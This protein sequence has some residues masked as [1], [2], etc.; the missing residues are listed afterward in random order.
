MKAYVIC[1]DSTSL[2]GLKRADID[3]PTPGSGQVLLKMHA[4]SL[5]FRDIALVT[6][7]YPG[8]SVQH[9]TIALSDGA[10]EVVAL[11]D[12][13][14]ELAVGDRV[15][16][17]FFQG[18]I[19]GPFNPAKHGV[20]G[21]PLDGVLTEYITVNQDGV[22]KIPSHLSYEEAATL[23]CAALTAW[24]A[25]MESTHMQPGQS[26]LALGTGGVSIFALQFARANGCHVFITSSSDDKLQRAKQMGAEGLINYKTTPDWGQEVLKLTNGTGVDNVI[27]VGGVGTLAKSFEA[28]GWHGQV[29][30]IGVLAGSEGQYLPHP[31][32]FKYARLQGIFV[33]NRDMFENMNKAIET[34]QIK[35]V[36][37][38]VFDFEETPA[39]FEYQLSGQH[40]GKIVIR[41]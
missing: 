22:V 21:S 3:K 18:L 36:I 29:S 32:M 11:G 14:S 38:K 35:P 10:G 41:I 40:F 28:V 2:D 39:A 17:T 6:G 19:N 33:G 4:A 20:L 9:D 34:N 27:E 8:G 13:V 37:D 1:K 25:L 30:L 16:P 5:N 7:H 26:V 23:P 15:T 12:G 24:N 31:L